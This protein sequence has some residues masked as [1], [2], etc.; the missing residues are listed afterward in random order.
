MAYAIF[1]SFSLV[2]AAAGI[3]CPHAHTSAHP[4]LQ[5]ANMREMPACPQPKGA[6][7]SIFMQ[8]SPFI[9]VIDDDDSILVSLS[10]LLRS[11]S[12][13]VATYRTAGAF[14]TALEHAQPDC[15]LTDVQ[16]PEISGLALQA[17][18]NRCYPLIPV[19]FMTAYPDEQVQARAFSAGALAFLHKPFEVETL[20]NLL[21]A[22]V[23]R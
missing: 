8:H 14:L 21:A 6:H 10:S 1:H 19:I 5:S 2:L 9:A 15:V 18:L 7:S 3:P 16:M 12:F 4:A 11:E 17:E 22:A 23:S 13:K 20:L